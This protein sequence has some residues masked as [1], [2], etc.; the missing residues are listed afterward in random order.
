MLQ[1]KGN[2]ILSEIKDFFTSSEKGILKTISLFQMLN[3]SDIKFGIK[4]FNQAS[5]KKGEIFLV[6]LLYPLFSVKNVHMAMKNRLSGY[7]DAHKDVYYR[8]K[9]NADINWR[10]IL[11][12]I[13]RRIFRE[14]K[15]SEH[16]DS[17]LPKCLIID[18][19]DLEK[20]GL[21]IEQIGKI[22]SHVSHRRILGFK[23][24]F[25]GYWDS[26][27]FYA[28]DF[29]LH[30][31]KG[32]NKKMPFG[33]KPSKLRKQFK[34]KRERKSCGY[35]RVAELRVDKISNAI[36]MIKKAVKTKVEIDYILMDSWFVCDKM[37]KFVSKLRGNINLI[38]M[39]KN[40]KAKYTFEN[41]ELTAKQIAEILKKRKKVK[42]VKKLN[43]YVAGTTLLYKG[44]KIRVFFCKTS[45]RGKWHLLVSTDISL[46]IERA[47]EIY[48]IR[49]SIEVFFKESKQYFGLGKCQA[50][51]FDA[52]IADI[53]INMIQY[54]LLSTAKRFVSYETLG[55]LF[56]ELQDNIRE[57]TISEKIWGLILEVL[58]IVVDFFNSDF[59]EL[60][61]NILK[62][63]TKNNKLINLLQ[64]SYL[65]TA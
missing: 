37:M 11:N 13:N 26:K 52:Q 36:S 6:L 51:D 22:W 15:N 17:I 46:S 18:D 55:Q 7:I 23:G 45:K 27:S 33:L 14:I 61:T 24:L 2:T 8:F 9:N 58:Q 48:S 49:W 53:T 43:M 64:S 65:K 59:N 60:I 63:D 42:R 20:T 39:L 12:T 31:E 5:Y 47:Y 50:Q 1:N 21:R 30:K 3:L 44:S 28:L 54:N 16:S 41:K 4:D 29:S 40:G 25:L 10:R 35:K 34:K 38:G 32:K 56:R 19:T 57:L 62:S